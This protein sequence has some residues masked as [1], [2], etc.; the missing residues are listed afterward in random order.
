MEILVRSF[1]CPMQGLSVD[2]LLVYSKDKEIELVVNLINIS[3][4]VIFVCGDIVFLV[5]SPFL[6]KDG[7]VKKIRQLLDTCSL[8][9]QSLKSTRSGVVEICIFIKKID[10]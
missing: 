10:I 3:F 6:C 7:Q 1:C 5:Y 2:V 8:F 9:R 4:L